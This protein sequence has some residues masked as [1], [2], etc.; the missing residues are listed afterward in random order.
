MFALCRSSF[1]HQLRRRQ[2]IGALIWL[3]DFCSRVTS[4][5]FLRAS[6]LSWLQLLLSELPMRV[7]DGRQ[8]S[9]TA[10]MRAKTH[11]ASLASKDKV[12]GPV[13]PVDGSL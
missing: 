11:G 10:E 2:A 1:G 9:L 6:F 13:G 3:F 12:G 5:I 4:P 8:L 7:S